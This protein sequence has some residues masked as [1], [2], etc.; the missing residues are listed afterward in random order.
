M[1]GRQLKKNQ[2]L[3][4]FFRENTGNYLGIWHKTNAIPSDFFPKMG[5]G[6]NTSETGKP[7]MGLNVFFDSR[8]QFF[9]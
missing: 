2:N 7:K 3:G 5:L 6:Q 8:T 1:P 9:A 4:H